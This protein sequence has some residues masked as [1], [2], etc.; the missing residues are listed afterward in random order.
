M[1]LVLAGSAVLMA[2]AVW[3]LLR[4]TINVQPWAAQGVIEDAHGSMTGRPA[5]KIGLWVFLAVV[6]VLFLLLIA[7]YGSRMAYEVWRPVPQVKLLWANTVVLVLASVALQ[8]ALV[9]ARRGRIDRMRAGLLAGGALTVLFLLGQIYAWQQLANTAYFEVTNPAIAFFYLITGA[10]G[11]HLLGGMVAWGRT[12]GRVWGDFA[13]TKVT[14]SVELCT[15][16][17]H[18]LLAVWLVLF[19][20]LFSGNNLD[21]LLTICGIR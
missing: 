11:L 6:A 4:H 20:L 17:W 2:V 21:L 7:A 16:Y 15:I 1:S 14:Q 18:F 12:A 19:G 10:H 3:W 9:A 8:W 5:I 13:A